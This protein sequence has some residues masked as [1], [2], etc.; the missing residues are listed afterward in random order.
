METGEPVSSGDYFLALASIGCGGMMEQLSM[1]DFSMSAT[2]SVD[3]P[4]KGG[5]C[6]ENPWGGKDESLLV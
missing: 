5:R 3:M 4:K 6:R 2:V 1:V